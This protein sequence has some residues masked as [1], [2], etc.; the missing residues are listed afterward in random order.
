MQRIFLFLMCTGFT[1]M[2]ND[3]F[4]LDNYQP[5]FMVMENGD[6]VR[7]FINDKKWLNSP[8]EIEFKKTEQSEP[9]LFKS[10]QLISFYFEKTGEYYYSTSVSFTIRKSVNNYEPIGSTKQFSGFVTVLIMGELSLYALTY[11]NV[12]YYFIQSEYENLREL[13]AKKTETG[14]YINLFK[15]T[16]KAATISCPQSQV[17]V[18]KLIYDEKSFFTFVSKYNACVANGNAYT[19]PKQKKFE[20]TTGVSMGVAKSYM[21]FE[22]RRRAPHLGSGTLEKITPTFGGYLMASLIRGHSR[23]SATTEAIY[24][25][26][27]DYHEAR[28]I[29]G[30][31]NYTAQNFYDIDYIKFGLSVRHTF[32]AKRVRFFSQVGLSKSQFLIPSVKTEWE[33]ESTSNPASGTNG[34]TGTNESGRFIG[35]GLNYRKLEAELRYEGNGGFGTEGVYTKGNCSYIMIKYQFAKF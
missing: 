9:I 31:F 28:Y 7:G 4:G 18:D 29:V 34:F 33:R 30:P 23:W 5:G 27:E 2:A 26:W 14:A 22:G 13:V 25:R 3:C 19:R 24:K 1:L 8:T 17:D 11:S 12:P 16:L 20:F 10:H 15:G 32:P 6:T 21:E 35:L